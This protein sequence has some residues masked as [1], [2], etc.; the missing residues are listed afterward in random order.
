MNV[1]DVLATQELS[2]ETLSIVYCFYYEKLRYTFIW[3]QKNT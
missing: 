2:V 1:E 3:V